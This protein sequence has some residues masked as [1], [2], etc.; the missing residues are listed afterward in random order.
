MEMYIFVAPLLLGGLQFSSFR[1]DRRSGDA[2]CVEFK[3]NYG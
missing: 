3:V 1:Y 2:A